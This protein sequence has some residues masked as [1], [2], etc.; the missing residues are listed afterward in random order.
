MQFHEYA[1]LSSSDMCSRSSPSNISCCLMT[2]AGFPVLKKSLV[3]C[4]ELVGEKNVF[5]EI[6]EAS[7]SV[8]SSFSVQSGRS[9][10]FG[11]VTGLRLVLV[12]LDASLTPSSSSNSKQQSSAL[13]EHSFRW[14]IVF[15]VTLRLR[16]SSFFPPPASTESLSNLDCFLL[17]GI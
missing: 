8:H 17:S 14:C 11:N 2:L 15:C 16:S 3:L 7:I 5:A 9:R 4:L 10:G 6:I 12:C 13:R 1:F